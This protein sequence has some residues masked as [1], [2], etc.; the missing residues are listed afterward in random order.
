M[1]LAS[2]PVN[3]VLLRRLPKKTLKQLFSTEAIS[4]MKAIIYLI[5]EIFKST[6][7]TSDKDFTSHGLAFLPNTKSQEL[8]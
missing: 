2:S 5:A 4:L 3:P 7:D 1:P 8:A 6:N